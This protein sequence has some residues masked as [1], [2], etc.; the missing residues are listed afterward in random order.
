MTVSPGPTASANLHRLSVNNTL[1]S[2]AMLGGDFIS[3]SGQVHGLRFCKEK[4][5]GLSNVQDTKYFY[6]IIRQESKVL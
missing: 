2:I 5:R 6:C 4:E 3:I 1:Q